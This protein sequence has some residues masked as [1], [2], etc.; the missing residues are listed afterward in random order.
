MLTGSKATMNKLVINCMI[1]TVL[2]MC[3]DNIQYLLLNC[4]ISCGSITHVYRFIG[5]TLQHYFQ[6]LFFFR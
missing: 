3:Y 5:S 6:L 2:F 4:I 1:L